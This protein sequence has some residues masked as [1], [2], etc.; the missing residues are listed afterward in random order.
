M[1]L[2]QSRVI[3]TQHYACKAATFATKLFLISMSLMNVIWWCL[4][5]TNDCVQG[6]LLEVLE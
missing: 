5:L 6:T 2:L 3:P 4:G 1:V